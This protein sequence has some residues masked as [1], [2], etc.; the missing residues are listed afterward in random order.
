MLALNMRSANGE[1]EVDLVVSEADR[2]L[3]LRRN[4][5]GISI[6]H[7]FWVASLDDL[8]SMKRKAGRPQDL[9]DIA[10]LEDIRRR[11]LR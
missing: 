9:T 1:I 2:F 7:E 3:E 5:I 10:A 11:S 8:I 6:R 4:A